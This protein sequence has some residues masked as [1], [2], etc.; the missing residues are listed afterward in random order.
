MSSLGVVV[1][2]PFIQINLQSFDV[3]V[4]LFTE[5]GLVEFLQDRLMEPFAD[6]VG[7]GRFHLGLRCP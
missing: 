5:C 4:E 1:V 2:E 6:T 3:F 7:L